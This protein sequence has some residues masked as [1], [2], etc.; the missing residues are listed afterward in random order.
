MRPLSMP[1]SVI[2][3]IHIPP[4]QK[5]EKHP[6]ALISFLRLLRHE[7]Y[8]YGSGCSRKVKENEE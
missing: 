7:K 6:K 2:Q 5:K 3:T 1:R 4:P 8:S